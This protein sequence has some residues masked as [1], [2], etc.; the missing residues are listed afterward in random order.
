MGDKTNGQK[1]VEEFCNFFQK[2]YKLHGTVLRKNLM[3]QS[4]DEKRTMSCL[5]DKKILIVDDDPDIVAA[6]SALLETF[7]PDVLSCG[8]GNAAMRLA[9]DEKPDMIIL[10]AM[11]PRRSGFLVMEKLGKSKKK[12]TRP[13]VIMITGNSGKR[14]EQCAEVF[15][16]DGYFQKPFRMG[17]L[18]KR[19]E[20]VFDAEG[21]LE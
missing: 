4:K 21:S 12:G 16:A 10:D 3:E 11:L 5:N 15:G 17:D 13:H 18:V 14:Y 1:I 8:D 7:T 6:I 2:L 9:L 20:E 19:M